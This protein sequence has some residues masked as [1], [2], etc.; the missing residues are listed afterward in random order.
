MMGAVTNAFG[1]CRVIMDTILQQEA[2]FN[3]DDVATLVITTLTLGSRPRQRVARLWAKKETWESLH[4][5]PG[6][7][8]V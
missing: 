5:L 3:K 7:Q 8:R 1:A 2:N 4:I 6:V